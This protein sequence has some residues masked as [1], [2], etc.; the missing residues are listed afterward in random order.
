MQKTLNREVF[1]KVKL[2]SFGELFW[3][4]IVEIQELNGSV[5]SCNDDISPEFVYAHSEAVK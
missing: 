3:D 1:D 4:E 2:G 5:S